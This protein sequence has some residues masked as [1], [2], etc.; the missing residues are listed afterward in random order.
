[1]AH[2][3]RMEDGKLERLAY[4]PHEVTHLLGLSI[5]S[6]RRHMRT[7]RLP[8]IQLGRRRL[9]PRD[10]L[11]ALLTP[12]IAPPTLARWVRLAF[13]D[14]SDPRLSRDDEGASE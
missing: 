9:I 10:V 3:K 14:P 1:M 6:V 8:S 5:D 12:E 2:T 4:S 7:G 11:R 13:Y